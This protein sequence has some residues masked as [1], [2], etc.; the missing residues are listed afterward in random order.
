M[1]IAGLTATERATPAIR[2]DRIIIFFKRYRTKYS[3]PG[4]AVRNRSGL[5]FEGIK[6]S[7]L[8]M[9]FKWLALG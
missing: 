8:D 3:L 2:P 7:L 1:S 9:L 5:A 6:S 4:F